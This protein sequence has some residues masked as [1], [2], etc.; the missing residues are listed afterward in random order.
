MRLCLLCFHLARVF[1]SIFAF[2][3]LVCSSVFALSFRF[4]SSACVSVLYTV[5]VCVSVLC[6]K[7]YLGLVFWHFR[8][9]L[10]PVY[11][12]GSKAKR[13]NHVAL[14]KGNCVA[15]GN[16]ERLCVFDV[17]LCLGVR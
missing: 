2:F 15:R 7:R 8:Y 6:G 16:A 5:C 10:L 17:V 13:R 12:Y 3:G 9:A 14:V 1:P 11:V 4:R